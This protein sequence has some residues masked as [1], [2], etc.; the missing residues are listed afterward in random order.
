MNTAA[1]ATITPAPTAQPFIDY[2]CDHP[3]FPGDGD[4]EAHPEIIAGYFQGLNDSLKT[5]CFSLEEDNYSSWAKDTNPKKQSAWGPIVTPPCCND[6]CDIKASAVELIYWPKPSALH[7]ITTLVDSTGFTYTYPSVYIVYKQLSATNDCGVLGTTFASLTRAYPSN[8]IQTV[9]YTG[10]Y[11]NYLSLNYDDLWS[12]CTSREP[13]GRKTVCNT[14]STGG[15]CVESYI[16]TNPLPVLEQIHCHPSIRY[17]S[18]LETLDPAW[19]TCHPANFGSVFDPPRMLTPGAAMDGAKASPDPTTTVAATPAPVITQPA[20]IK[21]SSSVPPV[22]NQPG[23]DPSSPSKQESKDP[24]VN[25]PLPSQGISSGPKETSSTSASLPAQ[26]NQPAQANPGQSNNG[27]TNNGGSNNADPNNNGQ[28]NVGQGGP[29]KQ[30]GNDQQGNANQGNPQQGNPQQGNSQQGNTQQGN[31][32]Q[33]NPQQ[34][35][36]NQGN[37]QQSNPQQGNSQQ[38]NTQQGNAQQGNSQQGNAQQDNSQQGNAQQGNAQQGNAQQGNA[39]QGNPQ[40]SNPQQGNSQQGDTQQGNA[41]QGNANQGNP[42]QS[43]SQQG[44]PQ[45]GTPQQ[46]NSQQGN[47]QQGNPQQGNQ[48]QGN[49]AAAPPIVTTILGH[50][51]QAGTSSGVIIVDGQPVTQGGNSVSE[52]GAPVA[53]QSN[54]DLLI[55]S[56]TIPS[57]I[58]VPNPTLGLANPAPVINIGG[59]SAT[60]LSNGVA[61]AGNTLTPNAPA[62]TVAGMP[63]SLGA[64]GLVIGS[65]TITLPTP[66]QALVS[67]A[68]GQPFTVLP[69]GVAIAGTTL[70]PQAPPITVGG[71]TISLGTNGLVVGTSTIPLGV[72]AAGQTGSVLPNGNVVV[73]DTTLT[74]NAPAVTIAGTQY[75]VGSGGL[76]VGSVTVPLASSSYPSMVTIAGQTYPVSQIADGIVVAGTTLRSAQPAITIA[77]AQV[78]IGTN[79]LVI[80]SS[81]VPLP[82]GVPP[83]P[84]V[85]IAG[86]AYAATK[87]A[88]GIAI[89]GTT[90][91]LGASPVTISGTPVSLASSGLVIGSSTIPFQ[92][93]A[94]STSTIGGLGGLII[95]GLGGSSQSTAT[96]NQGTGQTGFNATGKGSN[97]TEIFRGDGGR[98]SVQWVTVIVST[99]VIL[100]RGLI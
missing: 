77:G 12:N 62:V 79:G 5:Q 36:A 100:F 78:S 98:V 1:P 51:V 22:N 67:N 31:A 87:V 21:T 24:P 96:G 65:S 59:Q 72:P 6:Y 15:P 74:Q 60:V 43:N 30:Q 46:G 82:S 99:T 18:G 37:P 2:W 44:N 48:Q 34:G 8:E 40:Q 91:R 13:P 70:I 17:P 76:V 9:P 14:P 58:P 38:G 20:P 63:V 39:N 54:G 64:Q 33:G 83:L 57:F 80:G 71:T 68:A 4:M 32:Q 16:T 19:S 88:D 89:A 35:N 47:T 49:A 53:L 69:N 27:G 50:T 56:S 23:N 52:S 55:G 29:A 73:G 45:Q 41:Q 28:N 81:T 93:T 86:Q 26:N 92:A 3:R 95:S 90:I 42:Q 84:T 97:G 61:I 25:L 94:G 7:N 66:S 85:T 11:G 75:S 10:P